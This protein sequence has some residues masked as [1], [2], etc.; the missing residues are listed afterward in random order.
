MGRPGRRPKPAA[1]R[2][3]DGTHR[4]NRHGDAA[5]ASRR[6]QED[7]SGRT[8]AP[9]RSLTGEAR[10]EWRRLAESLHDRG[11]LT[12][13]HRAAFAAYCQAWADM[14]AAQEALAKAGS[15]YV[16]TRTGGAMLH[17]AVTDYH[18][19][20]YRLRNFVQEFGLSP[21]AEGR[22]AP[23][24]K[25]QGDQLDSLASEAQ[26]ARKVGHERPA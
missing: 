24:S 11:L 14:V 18:Q 12:H 10:A 22:L 9:P 8:P 7:R 3:V 13:R 6:V 2:L 1:L 5:E 16:P 23:P 21:V 26:N 25:R 17:P 4:P 20:A 15:R 19:A